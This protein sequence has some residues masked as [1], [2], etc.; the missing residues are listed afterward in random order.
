MAQSGVVLGKR[1]EFNATARDQARLEVERYLRSLSYIYIYPLAGFG[2]SI[3][4]SLGCA[5]IVAIVR[6]RCP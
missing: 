3:R 1:V 5:T 2:L 6:P 4:Q